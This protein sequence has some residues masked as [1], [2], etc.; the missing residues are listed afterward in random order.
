MW[1]SKSF[2]LVGWV[3]RS[4]TQQVIELKGK[5]RVSRNEMRVIGGVLTLNKNGAI[6]YQSLEVRLKTQRVSELLDTSGS[7]SSVFNLLTC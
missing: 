7:H 4:E 2:K 1:K 5:I 6:R 3:E